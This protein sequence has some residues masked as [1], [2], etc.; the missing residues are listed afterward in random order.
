MTRREKALRQ[1]LS[2][3][4]SLPRAFGRYALFDRIGKGGMAEIF[5]AQAH[6][7]LGGTRLVVVKQI[8]PELAAT[9]RFADLLVTE[10]K[11]AA[12]L[13]HPLPDSW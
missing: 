3:S 11:L 9:T 2:D 1:A 6:T 7:E 5:L 13:S 4:P 12:R 10:A 8:L